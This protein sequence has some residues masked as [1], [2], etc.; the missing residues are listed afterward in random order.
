MPIDRIDHYAI[1]TEK[2]EET[3]DFYVDIVGLKE[4]PR[5][6]FGFAGHWLYCGDTAVIHLIHFDRNAEVGSESDGIRGKREA[7]A[8]D[9]TGSVDH[10][11]FRA[12]DVENFR[13]NLQNKDISIRENDIPDFDLHQIFLE[14]P[15]GVTIELN[16]FGAA[17]TM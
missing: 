1:R 15:N 17:S 14:D 7:F 16:F 9:G 2:L 3:R 8:D 11:A 12:S 13:K 4:G 10:L 5:P 6:K